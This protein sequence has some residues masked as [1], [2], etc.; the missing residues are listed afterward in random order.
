MGKCFVRFAS[1]RRHLQLWRRQ[2]EVDLL[3]YLEVLA[4]QS[5]VAYIRKPCGDGEGTVILELERLLLTF[6]LMNCWWFQTMAGLFSISYIY[7]GCHPNPIDFKSIIFQDGW[8]HHQPDW[9]GHFFTVIFGPALAERHQ[10][11][12]VRMPRQDHSSLIYH[13][14]M[15]YHDILW[16]L[17]ISYDILIYYDL[18]WYVMQHFQNSV[19]WPL[20]LKGSLPGR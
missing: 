7:M 11:S 3:S 12:K 9:Y 13:D 5:G 4:G 17:M 14:I 6:R 19:C 16:S 20:Y 8:N 1:F 18:L 2:T 15:I 10:V